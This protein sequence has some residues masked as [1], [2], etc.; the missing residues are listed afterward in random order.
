MITI[1]QSALQVGFSNFKGPSNIIRF[2]SFQFA[3]YDEVWGEM[4]GDMA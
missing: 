1:L 4:S 3:R 2:D